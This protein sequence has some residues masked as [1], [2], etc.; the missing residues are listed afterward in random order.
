M[1]TVSFP[2]NEPVVQRGVFVM[3]PAKVDGQQIKC[4]ITSEALCD[5]F[6]GNYYDP[7]S[8]FLLNHENIKRIATKL[9]NQSRFESDG[10]ILIKTQDI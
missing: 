4:S 2:P 5:R 8:A 1:T 10:A 3:F 9:I 6:G 7:R